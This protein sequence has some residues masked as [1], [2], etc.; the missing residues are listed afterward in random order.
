MKECQTRSRG[1][2]ASASEYKVMGRRA[3]EIIE[4]RLEDNFL[5]GDEKPTHSRRK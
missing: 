3:L 2:A 4:M 1:L 5:S